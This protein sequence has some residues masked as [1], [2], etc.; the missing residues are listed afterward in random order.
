MDKYIF[1]ISAFLFCLITTILIERRLIPALSVRARQP[2]YEDGPKWH[3]SKTG[4]PTMG[5]IA[6]LISMSVAMLVCSLILIVSDINKKAGISLLLTTLFAIFNSLIGIFD[7]LMKLHRNKNAGLTP[8]QKLVLQFFISVIF[9][10]A[11]KH[12][13]D[14]GSTVHILTKEI[15][16]G[17][18]YYPLAII[19]LLGVVNCANLTDGIDGL[20]TSVAIAIGVTFL[21]IGYSVS[22]STPIIASAMVGGGCGFLFFNVNPAKIFMGDT[23]SLF[24]GAVAVGL[25]FSLERALLII[26]IG[27]VYV[28][29]GLSVIL[30]VLV[31]KATKKRLFKMAPLHHH[32]EKCGLTENQIC[33][34]AV[35][36]T[37]VFSAVTILL[38]RS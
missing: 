32:M 8:T 25:A 16:L 38:S 13:L 35:I 18:F 11:R 29:E 17:V 27:I 28:I 2:I 31:Y 14:D 1:C 21:L 23:G 12:F 37:L 26:P 36:T 9:L 6:F 3:L 24:L 22:Y 19:L 7:D 5:G 20:A 33:I 10:M 15:D 4:T 30:Q 34:I